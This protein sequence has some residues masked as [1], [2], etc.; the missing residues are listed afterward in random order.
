MTGPLLFG[1]SSLSDSE[2]TLTLNSTID[3]FIIAKR[4]DDPIVT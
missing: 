2:I 4:F 3:Y 1:N